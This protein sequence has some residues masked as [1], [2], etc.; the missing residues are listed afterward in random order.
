MNIS[1][2]YQKILELLKQAEAVGVD[3]NLKF[4]IDGLIWHIERK[5]SES[6]KG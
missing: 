3:N 6:T 2:W 4:Y 5:I 1:E